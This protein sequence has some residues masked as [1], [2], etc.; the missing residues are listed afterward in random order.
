MQFIL[1]SLFLVP[2]PLIIWAR[3]SF[4]QLRPKAFYPSACIIV[5]PSNQIFG[6]WT[7]PVTL[8][9][10]SPLFPSI[11]LIELITF[12]VLVTHNC[13]VNRIIY[14]TCTDHIHKQ[15]RR[16]PHL[17][18][19][20]F[21][22]THCKYLHLWATTRTRKW[23]LMTG[24]LCFSPPAQGVCQLLFLHHMLLT[25]CWSIIA[26][27]MSTSVDTA[28]WSINTWRIKLNHDPADECPSIQQIQ[29]C[30]NTTFA[31]A[32]LNDITRPSVL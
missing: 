11:Y 24:T 6:H 9:L 18:S 15:W 10:Q 16:K 2:S 26:S 32:Q 13:S 28:S 4:R 25:R 22:S 31:T 23:F 17:V 5:S 14:R 12:L 21:K 27:V 30:W 1:S 19:L 29:P 20:A 8:P 7:D 3:I